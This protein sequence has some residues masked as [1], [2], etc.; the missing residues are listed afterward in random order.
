MKNKGIV[1]G[2]CISVVV[3]AAGIFVISNR[4][5]N[6]N[7]N[8]SS[9]AST[10]QNEAESLSDAALL[11]AIP[12]KGEEEALTEVISDSSVQ[13]TNG[14]NPAT[15]NEAEQAGET[16]P[17]SETGAMPDMTTEASTT[18]AGLLSGE[19]NSS[20]GEVKEME[21]P[22]ESDIP[23]GWDW[24]TP[25]ETQTQ[26]QSSTAESSST[27]PTSESEER[28]GEPEGKP[29]EESSSEEGKEPEK[30]S[31]SEKSDEESSSEQ[32]EPEVQSSEEEGSTEESETEKP[33]YSSEEQSSIV[34]SLT[35]PII[36]PPIFFN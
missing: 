24:N 2:I 4:K 10:V 28:Q 31:G 27:E 26:M 3:I 16:V 7:A 29:G 21:L 12:E 18:N 1:F 30:E 33:T 17:Q 36:L 8:K 34:E 25:L 9:I 20:I 11:A 32:G 14:E 22:T 6:G 23:E 13:K 15:G 5:S 19:S 35:A